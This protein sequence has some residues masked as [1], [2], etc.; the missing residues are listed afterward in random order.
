MPQPLQP[1]SSHLC[2][3]YFIYLSAYYLRQGHAVSVALAGLELP[4]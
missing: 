4:V 1:P 3:N 2:G